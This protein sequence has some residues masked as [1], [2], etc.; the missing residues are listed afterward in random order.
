[1]TRVQ[2]KI[3][4]VED[5]LDTAEILKAFFC[6]QG[7]EV[8]TVHAG[9]DGL[10]VCD[11]TLPDVLLLDLHPPDL[12]NY[13]FARRLRNNHQTAN[14]PIIFLT[15]K[16]ARSELLQGLELEAD[17]YV[18]KPFNLQEVRLVIH[19][20]IHRAHHNTLTDPITGLPEG[21][22]VDERLSE[23]VNSSTWALL[24]I[25]LE[26]LDAFRE[27]YGFVASDDVLRAV[28]LMAN[29]I[30]TEIG[31][32]GDFLG[33]LGQADLVLITVPEQAE[34]L[35]ERLRTRLDQSISYFYPIKDR[36][37]AIQN[38]AQLAVK[39]GLLKAG[40]PASLSLESLKAAL[41]RRKR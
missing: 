2:L 23:C 35:L 29:N 21:S 18:P 16:R 34:N 30:L 4:I 9:E 12:D 20:A 37:R 22:V 11:D 26:H 1:M 40:D 13:E 31:R 32:K 6:V 5:D 33:H 38:G 28:V 7:Y 10:R 36:E 15:E 19:N 25:S 39:L 41:L 27:A 17:D 3:L 14:I 8:V 24:L